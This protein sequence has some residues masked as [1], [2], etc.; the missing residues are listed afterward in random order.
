MKEYLKKRI[1]TLQ[2]NYIKEV[3]KQL[4]AVAYRKL[5]EVQEILMD[6]QGGNIL[7]Y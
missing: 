3:D 1:K 7:I 5:L 6:F 2:Q 4:K